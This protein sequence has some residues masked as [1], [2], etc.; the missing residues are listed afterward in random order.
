LSPVVGTR[1]RGLD[2]GSE[3]EQSDRSIGSRGSSRGR[4]RPSSGGG[5]GQ[6]KPPAAKKKAAA[7]KQ[8]QK[9]KPAAAYPDDGDSMYSEDSGVGGDG[10]G[11]G[12]YD[13]GAEIAD[14]DSRLNALQSFLRQAKESTGR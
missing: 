3:A 13:T 5:S 10:G 7:P 2:S 1:R 11:G 9:Q 4:S 12:K 6:R 8:K 14:I